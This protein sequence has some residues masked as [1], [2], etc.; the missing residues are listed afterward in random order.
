MLT[1]LQTDKG[2]CY[3]ALDRVEFVSNVFRNKGDDDVRTVGLF[4][5][6]K[7]YVLN[8][9]DNLGKLGLP[10]D[11]ASQTDAPRPRRKRPTMTVY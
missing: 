9:A 10:A 5:G 7:A 11:A 2:L 1:A 4:G 6:S 8:T 3:L